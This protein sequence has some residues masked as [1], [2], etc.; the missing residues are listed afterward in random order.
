MFK[1]QK[2]NIVL[3]LV[4]YIGVIAILYFGGKGWAI[5]LAQVQA[6]ADM[7]GIVEFIRVIG[8][9]V[10]FIGAIAGYF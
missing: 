5:N 10:P 4:V 9:S 6:G 7:N 8:I 1:N 2:G 3:S